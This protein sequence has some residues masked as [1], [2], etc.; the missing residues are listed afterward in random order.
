MAALVAAVLP[1]AEAA[2]RR[3]A[4]R[5]VA[6]AAAGV[7]AA[8]PARLAVLRVPAWL[9]WLAALD[10]PVPVPGLSGSDRG[11]VRELPLVLRRGVIPLPLW[12]LAIVTCP[13]A[14]R[15]TGE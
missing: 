2:G 9:A 7:A 12:H 8:V 11:Q 13:A 15:P 14:T 6:E 1:A 5:R 4:G 10:A 3:L